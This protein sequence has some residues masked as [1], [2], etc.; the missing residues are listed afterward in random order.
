MSRRHN[1]LG[2]KQ[3]IHKNWMDYVVGLLLRG[4]TV[5]EIRSNL[6]QYLANEKPY[7]GKVPHTHSFI[8]SMLSSWFSPKNELEELRNNALKLIEWENQ[9]NWLPYHWAIISAS[10]P[11]WFNIAMQTG[12]LFNLQERVTKDQI[13]VRLR[14]IY[15][16]KESVWHYAGYVIRSFVAWGVIK[17]TEI[18]GTY[19]KCKAIKVDNVELAILL[20]KSALHAT[21]DG[22]MSFE[23]LKNNPALFPF[24]LPILTGDYIAQNSKTIDIIRYGLDEQL[25]QLKD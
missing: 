6:D 3:T 2:I 5:E 23:I 25:L 18:N 1:T 20:Y 13:T 21:R 14:E 17:D 24:E 10:Y 4:L 7:T 15:G 12:R 9:E 22:K 19:E 16:D 11:F 8:K